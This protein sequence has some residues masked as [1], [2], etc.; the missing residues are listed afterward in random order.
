[1]KAAAYVTLIDYKDQ[2]FNYMF[3]TDEQ[4][5]QFMANLKGISGLFKSIKR[6]GC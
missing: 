1:M 4:A 2:V 6:I 5:A 3:E